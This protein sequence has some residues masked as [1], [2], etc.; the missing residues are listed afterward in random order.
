M[1]NIDMLDEA[2][3]GRSL[4]R[5]YTKAPA[6]D[7]EAC[8]VKLR[9]NHLSAVKTPTP[10]A[11][12]G[13]LDEAPFKLDTRVKEIFGQTLPTL[14]I[15]DAS[16]NDQFA[17]QHAQTMP[18]VDEEESE[19]PEI[20][21]ADK[22]IRD[23]FHM[24]ADNM[25]KECKRQCTDVRAGKSKPCKCQSYSDKIL[26]ELECEWSIDEISW[27][28]LRDNTTEIIEHFQ[29]SHPDLGATPDFGLGYLGI[30]L[31]VYLHAEEYQREKCL[32]GPIFECLMGKKL[33]GTVSEASLMYFRRMEECNARHLGIELA[34]ESWYVPMGAHWMEKR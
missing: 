24:Y 3:T 15:P 31:L 5:A 16:L 14:E 6:I 10:S 11:E 34:S 7:L 4:K 8:I 29:K 25:A 27:K 2:R 20:S 21:K 12:E 26:T 33:D 30:K 28:R 32:F 18:V 23:L 22:W 19:V 9:E 17:Q 13:R 1:P